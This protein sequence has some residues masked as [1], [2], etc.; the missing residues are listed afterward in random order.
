MI[1]FMIVGVMVPGGLGVALPCASAKRSRHLPEVF[2][3][4]SYVCRRLSL[5]ERAIIKEVKETV[6][7]LNFL[8]TGSVGCSCEKVGYS[9]LSTDLAS[10]ELDRLH[11]VIF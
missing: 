3:D 8:E 5:R 1:I 11:S 2:D 9:I 6:F 7:A 4:Y 10:P